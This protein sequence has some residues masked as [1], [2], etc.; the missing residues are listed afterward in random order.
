[1]HGDE[2]TVKRTVWERDDGQ[3]AF[4]SPTGSRWTERRFLEYHHVQPY[5]HQGPATVDNIALR[6]W[7]HNQYE[8][9]LTF[10]PIGP[11]IVREANAP[12]G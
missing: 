9:E 3:C 1:V 6:C 10:G 2:L 4:L 12:Y 7:R 5:A 11:S 8:A